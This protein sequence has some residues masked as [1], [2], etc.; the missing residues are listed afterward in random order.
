MEVKQQT[1]VVAQEMETLREEVQDLQVFLRKAW[2]H[3]LGALVAYRRRWMAPVACR[4]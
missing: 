3:P 1:E 2:G 4:R